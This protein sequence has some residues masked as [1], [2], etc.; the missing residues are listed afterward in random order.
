MGRVVAV[1]GNS[2][3][4]AMQE[5]LK[6][7][8]RCVLSLLRYP[9]RFIAKLPGL[10]SQ[11]KSLGLKFESVG[12]GC[13]ALRIADVARDGLVEEYNQFHEKHGRFHLVITRGMVILSVNQAQG[14]SELML[15]VLSQAPSLMLL[16]Y[17][18]E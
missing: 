3:V 16:I 8:R 5:E 11:R 17:R 10:S 18:S 14:S 12:Q 1:N 13:T 15:R 7:S 2:S 9:P 4:E 6:T